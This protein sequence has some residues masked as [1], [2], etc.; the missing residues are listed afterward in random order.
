M[1]DSKV[2]ELIEPQYGFWEVCVLVNEEDSET[3]KVKKT[4]EVHLVDGVC[5]TD[6]EKKV[7]EEMKGT[8]WEW[9]IE[10]CKKSKITFVY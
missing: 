10:S 9:S 6:V 3:G 7:A 2:A 5:V 8:M 1:A 4:K